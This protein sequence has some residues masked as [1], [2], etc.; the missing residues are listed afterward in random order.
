LFL[1]LYESR[2]D[3]ERVS[4][5]VEHL[6]NH[7]GLQSLELPRNAIGPGGAA[8]IAKMVKKSPTLHTLGLGDN[9]LGK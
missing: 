3:D 4:T 5:L 9:K 1:R 2:I 6:M 7:P 8:S